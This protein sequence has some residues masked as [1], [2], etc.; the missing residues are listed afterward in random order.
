MLEIAPE[1]MVNTDQIKKSQ[2]DVKFQKAMD[3]AQLRE[4]VKKACSYP[5]RSLQR[6]RY[7]SQV[8]RLVQPRL[9]REAVDYYADALQQTWVYF[10]NNICEAGTAAEPYNPNRGS[11][12]TWLNAYLQRRL[13][14][15]FSQQQD[16]RKRQAKDY[17]WRD[18]TSGEQ[19]ESNIIDN[20]AAPSDVPPI[21]EAVYA[22][23]EEDASGQLR[24]LHIKGHP[25]ANAQVLLLRRL[26]PETSWKT[27]SQELD[28]DIS[29][30]SSFYQ[31][32]CLPLLRQF[33]ASEG[34]L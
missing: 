12:A 15:G 27:L 8:V 18:K 24:S 23:V 26:P 7:L 6:N 19:D 17:G 22:W 33:G 3:D 34:F 13:Q 14:D 28:L 25:E 4:L 11:V 10:C 2:Q 29:T 20:L 5:P 1:Y 16:T 32:K 31:R 21:L 9:W 30:L